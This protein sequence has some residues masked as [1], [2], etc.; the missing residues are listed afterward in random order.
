MK[1]LYQ[2]MGI[3]D[4]RESVY[5]LANAAYQTLQKQ[6]AEATATILVSSFMNLEVD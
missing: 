2:N 3:F 5:Q 1:S 4:L 6:W